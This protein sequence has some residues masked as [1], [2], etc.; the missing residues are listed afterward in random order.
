MLLLPIHPFHRDMGWF[1]GFKIVTLLLWLPIGA[2]LYL[3]FRPPL[4]PTAVQVVTFLVSLVTAYTMRFVI[5]WALGMLTFW[6]TRVSAVFDLF[7]A[8]ELLLSGRL[9]PMDLLPDWAQT[10]GRLLP[11]QWAFGF[12]IE[13]LLGRLSASEIVLGFG[14]QYI[15]FLIGSA[16]AWFLWRKGVGRYTAVGA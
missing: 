4:D 10:L 7:F 15:W 11:F 12:P 14:A 3:I 8:V 16:A 1:A 2:G 6:M 5:L 9:V 13:V